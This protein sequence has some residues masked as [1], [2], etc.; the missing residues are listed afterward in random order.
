MVLPG[1]CGG[2]YPAQSPLVDAERSINLYPEPSEGA[3]SPMALYPTPGLETFATLTEGPVRGIFGQSGRCLAVGGRH[4]YDISSAGVVTDRGTMNFDN[5]IATMTTNGDGGDELFVVSGNTGYVLNLTSNVLTNVVSGVTICGMLDGYFL[6]LDTT[7]STLKISDLL[8][9]LTW[10]PLQIAQRSTAS[11]PWRSLLVVG[12][13][14]LL[15]GE[16]T[17]ELWYDTGDTFPFAPFPGALIPVGIAGTFCAAQVGNAV[18]WLA[19]DAT[20]SRTVV[21]AQGVST[22][23]V[24]TFA[25]DAVLASMDTVSDAEA[26]CYQEL[27]HTFFVLNFPTANQTLVW[28][29]TVSLW[30]ERG[31]WDVADNRF[32]VDRPRVHTAIYDQHLVGDRTSGAVYTMRADVAT[33]ADGDGIRRLRLTA[34]TQNEQV[35]V[36]YDALRVFLEPGLGLQSGQ[37]SD[38]TAVLRYSDDGGKTWSNELARSAG[39]VGQYRHIVEWNRLGRSRYPRVWELSLSDP[40]PWRILGAWLNPP[41]I[42]NVA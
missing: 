38:P 39:T 35:P 11:D 7:T 14:I 40:I 21:K 1:F 19:Q 3:L 4:L 12:K 29:D 32:N 42:S 26:F 22:S 28:D 6:A 36:R 18:M 23:K 16:F 9:G 34:G 10:D 33:D 17:S 8:D 37:G 5:N 20:G 13:N 41:R 24:S 15:F 25:V 27:G 30:H 31:D 2:S